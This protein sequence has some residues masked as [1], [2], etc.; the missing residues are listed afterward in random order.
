M[1][2]KAIISCIK[3]SK[4]Q[5]SDETNKEQISDRN[6]QQKERQREKNA[7]MYNMRDERQT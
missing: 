4:S 3:T 7:K 1:Q 5:L 2:T 6:N